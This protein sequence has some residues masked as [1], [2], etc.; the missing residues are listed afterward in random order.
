MLLHHA[1]PGD[2]LTLMLMLAEI[3]ASAGCKKAFSSAVSERLARS[4]QIFLQPGPQSAQHLPSLLP[5][6]AP[7]EVPVG[8]P[9]A[10]VGMALRNFSTLVPPCKQVQ[11]RHITAGLTRAAAT[12]V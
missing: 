12:S 7:P 3:S 11:V 6:S 8:T 2:E 1:P 9:Q 10:A 5:F 4:T